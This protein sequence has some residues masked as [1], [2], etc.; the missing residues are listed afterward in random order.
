[1]IREHRQVVLD[2]LNGWRVTDDRARIDDKTW[3][4][5]WVVLD[6]PPPQREAQ[7]WARMNQGRAAGWF[8]T[9][10]VGESVDQAG[11]LHDAVTDLLLDWTPVLDGWRAWP[12]ETY[13][14][15][16]LLPW[17]TDLP[18]RRL[19]QVVCRWTWQAERAL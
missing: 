15:P 3:K 8:Q 13:T 11:R 17:N 10:C 14:E 4:A 18:D 2:R 19:H 1:M 16:R 6:F 12:V 9:A 5:P 7:R